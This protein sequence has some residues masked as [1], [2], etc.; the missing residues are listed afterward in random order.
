MKEAILYEKLDDKKVRCNVC[1]N[2]CTIAPGKCGYCRTRLNRDGTLYTLI[3]NKVSSCHANPIEKKPLF[4]FYPG[5]FFFSMGTLGCNFRCPGCQNWEISRA[6]IEES[7]DGTVEVTPEKSIELTLRYNCKELLIEREGFGI[8][9]FNIKDSK[10]PKCGT[11]I[12]G[13]F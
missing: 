13:R 12:F 9:K 4:H 7:V 3:Y 10:C 8:T 1:R 2:R 6:T 5:S 11:V